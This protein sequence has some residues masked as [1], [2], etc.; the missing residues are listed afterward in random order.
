MEPTAGARAVGVA[1]RAGRAFAGLGATGQTTAVVRKDGAGGLQGPRRLT[2]RANPGHEETLGLVDQLRRE[3]PRGG[4]GRLC[5]VPAGA[6][7]HPRA[8]GPARVQ[9]IARGDQRDT[10]G[11]LK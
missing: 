9:V 6:R 4:A 10:S 5:C 1:P 7:G 2:T 8:P 11:N 3:C